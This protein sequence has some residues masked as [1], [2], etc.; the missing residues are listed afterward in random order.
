MLIVASHGSKPLMLTEM[1]VDANLFN[2]LVSLDLILNLILESDSYDCF[3]WCFIGWNKPDG[4]Q[5]TLIVSIAFLGHQYK[6]LLA[7]RIVNNSSSNNIDVL[8][9]PSNGLCI[10]AQ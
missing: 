5:L 8:D 4:R 9:I 10:L 3:L 2:C 1:P 6:L 7:T